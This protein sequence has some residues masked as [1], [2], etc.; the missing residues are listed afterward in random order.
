MNRIAT[1]PALLGLGLALLGSADA[2]RA[3][4]GLPLPT[5]RPT[6]RAATGDPASPGAVARRFYD[7]FCTGDTATMEA[8]Y[9]PDVRF[10]DEIFSFADRAGTMGMWRLLVDPKNG[11]RFSYTLLGV[12]GDT[13][14]VRWIADYRFLGRPVH[15]EVTGRLRVKDGRIVDHHDAFSWDRWARQAL[16]LGRF[17]T[18][19]PIKGLIKVGLRVGLALQARRAAPHAASPPAAP[20]V[21][22]ID[23]LP[24]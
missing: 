8:L 7:A 21:G 14:V 4:S 13:A 19:Q 6:A 20:R 1:L 17:S 15:N 10:Q 9:A 11:G 12:E 18:F 16:P 24:R 3:Q 22:L 23:A 5:A 2:A